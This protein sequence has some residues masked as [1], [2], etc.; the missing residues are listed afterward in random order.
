M[1]M[2]EINK[3]CNTFILLI[4]LTLV[5]IYS[6]THLQFVCAKQKE[7]DKQSKYRKDFLHTNRHDFV[8][9]T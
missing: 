7:K 3:R 4:R 9:L 6:N 2:I 8:W 5:N 1:I